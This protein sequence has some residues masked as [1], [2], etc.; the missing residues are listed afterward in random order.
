MQ[1]FNKTEKIEEKQQEISN[2][3]D[4][5]VEKEPEKVINDEINYKS[6][7][8]ELVVNNVKQPEK[9]VVKPIK[10]QETLIKTVV[11]DSYSNEIERVG[12]VKSQIKSGSVDLSELKYKAKNEG[13]KLRISSEKN[14]LTTHS[15]YLNKVKLLSSFTLL[16]LVMLEFMF[17]A[18]NYKNLFKITPV[19][20]IIPAIFAILFPVINAINYGKNPQKISNK[21]FKKDSVFTV[22]IIVFNLILITF[23][24]LLLTN[25]NL[26]DLYS[27]LVYFVFPVTLYLDVFVYFLLKFVFAKNKEFKVKR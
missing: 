14:G 15:F 6:I 9:E 17:F 27:L 4:V 11:K 23:A 16:L 22:L 8:G 12:G 21:P 1:N 10:K 26:R 24:L 5:L 20:I 13:Y 7:L 3:T 2:K 19:S 18:L 25:V